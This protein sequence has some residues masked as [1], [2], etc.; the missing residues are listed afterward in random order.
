MPERSSPAIGVVVATRGRPDHLGRLLEALRRQSLRPELFSVVAVNDGSHDARYAEILEPHR[1]VRY[2]ALPRRVGPAAA[3]NRGAAAVQ[4]EWLVFTDDDCRPPAGWLEGLW[5]RGAAI[6]LAGGRVL[7]PPEEPLGAV[8]RYLRDIGFIRNFVGEDGRIVCIPSANLAVRKAWF[9]RVGG[10][11]ERFPYP[12]GEDMDLTCRLVQA[13]ARAEI[14]DSWITYHPC[15]CGLPDFCRRYFRYGYGEALFRGLEGGAVLP[16]LP[17]Y[18]RRIR[19]LLGLAGK[20][21]RP[22][23]QEDLTFRLLR[24]TRQ[25]SYEMGRLCGRWRG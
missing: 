3:R 22:A 6:D 17:P 1:G 20:A 5:S 18:S 12:G 4:G 15:Q 13:G 23:A 25:V 24:L 14:L 2:L 11:D 7:P 21:A 8:G 10:F 16:P 19:L 9:D